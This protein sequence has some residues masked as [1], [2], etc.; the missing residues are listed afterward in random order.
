MLTEER[1]QKIQEL[2]SQEKRLLVNEISERFDVS[3]VTIRKDLE[4]LEKR[5]ALSR[6]HGGAIR[7]HSSVMDLALNEKE[8][9]HTR[10]KIRIARAAE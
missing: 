4:V 1:R 7:N 2:L 9:I 3:A 8:Q 5:G 10:E 6:V